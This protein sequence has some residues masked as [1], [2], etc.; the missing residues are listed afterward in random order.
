MYRHEGKKMGTTLEVRVDFQEDNGSRHD[1]GIYQ[2]PGSRDLA[3]RRRLFLGKKK[4]RVKTKRDKERRREYRESWEGR[5]GEGR[6][7]T[8]GKER[9]RQLHGDDATSIFTC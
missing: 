1:K 6:G 2:A 5:E 7:R 9:W 8:G 3:R 4:P